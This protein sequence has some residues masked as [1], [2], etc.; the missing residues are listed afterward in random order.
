[1]KLAT[2]GDA[3]RCSYIQTSSSSVDQE[4][5]THAPTSSGSSTPGNVLPPIQ[6][7]NFGSLLAQVLQHVQLLIKV[8]RL[9]GECRSPE[10]FPATHCDGGYSRRPVRHKESPS[11]DESFQAI[12]DPG[13]IFNDGQITSTICDVNS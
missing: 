9:V 3:W 8:A 11:C 6:S 1:M 12:H 4:R 10:F 5:A 2:T 13:K 7:S